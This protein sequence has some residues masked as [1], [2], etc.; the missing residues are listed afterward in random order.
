MDA[1]Q[2][3]SR[4]QAL[5]SGMSDSE[6]RRLCLSGKW[7]RVRAGHYLNAAAPELTAAGRHLVLALATCEA[8]SDA[9][10]A[11]HCSALVLHGVPTWSIS[12]QRVHLTRNR[13]HGGR[14][15][16]QLVVHSAQLEPD[17]I[18]LVNG[19]QVTTPPRTVIDIA[20]SQD[21]EQAVVIGDSALRQGLTTADELRDHLHRARHRRGSRSAA[22]V[23]AFLDGRS[24]S[25]GESRSRV[26]IHRS[27]LPAPELQARVFTD[28]EVCVGRVD[29][30]F[31]GLG[32]IG[33]F[34]GKVSC[35]SESQGAQ[36]PEQVL[37][38]KN[39]DDRLRAL[40]WMVVR[41]N[42]DDLDDPARLAGR[43]RSAADVAARVRRTGHW[44]PTPKI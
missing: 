25:I 8:T 33:E 36:R 39:R 41:W 38:E 13:V 11:S 21:F 40:G 22:Q 3:I 14:I 9:A 5:A 20:R 19:L 37:A 18:T 26:A 32:V 31:A 12:L 4:R 15:G 6:L 44:S 7:R 42:W 1:P 29:F 10:V 17:E 24:E 28:D 23:V 43:I 34:D 27:G 35:Q 2:L 16:K 30:L